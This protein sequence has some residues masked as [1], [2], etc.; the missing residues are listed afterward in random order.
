MQAVGDWS[1][2][3]PDRGEGDTFRQTVSFITPNGRAGRPG[4]GGAKQV[5]WD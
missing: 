1:G 4:G 5:T 3:G 2:P